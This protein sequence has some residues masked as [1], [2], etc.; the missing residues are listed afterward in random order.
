MNH[1]GV[2]PVPWLIFTNFG[3]RSTIEKSYNSF[4][5]CLFQLWNHLTAVFLTVVGLNNYKSNRK[6]SVVRRE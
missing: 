2:F 5:D 4:F 6:T 3:Q 1:F